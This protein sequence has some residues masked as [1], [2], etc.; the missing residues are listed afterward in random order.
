MTCGTRPARDRRQR[1]INQKV[2]GLSST[3]CVETVGLG[4][5]LGEV[6]LPQ[7]LRDLAS[8]RRDGPGQRVRNDRRTLRE[9]DLLQL[10]LHRHTYSGRTLGAQ[11]GERLAVRRL[12]DVAFGQCA[13]PDEILRGVVR[14][15]IG[16][17]AIETSVIHEIG[18]LKARFARL[19]ILRRHQKPAV[20]GDEP[21]REG[22]RLPVCDAGRPG[23]NP[24][25]CNGDKEQDPFQ[26]VAD[27]INRMI[28]D[29][30]HPHG[31]LPYC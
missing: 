14:T 25:R 15:E 6:I 13:E 21:I 9:V 20:V 23:K 19:N 10:R 3:L 2:G 11:C 8:Q 24:K 26:D 1:G 31:D 28:G 18:F 4:P 16:S 5:A 12:R 29:W 27:G 22:R 30:F 7:L 17:H